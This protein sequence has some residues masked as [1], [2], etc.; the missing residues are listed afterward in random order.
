MM[1]MMSNGQDGWMV[2]GM[3][4]FSVLFW[5]LVIASAVFIARGHPEKPLC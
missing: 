3:W 2:G 1:D 5:V 4:F